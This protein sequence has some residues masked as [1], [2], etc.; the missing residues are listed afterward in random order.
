M[1]SHAA[2]SI[3]TRRS[4]ISRIKNSENQESWREFYNTYWKLVYGV[5]RRAG[6]TDAEAQDAVQETFCH[7]VKSIPA[8]RYDPAVGSFKSWLLHTTRWHIADQLRARAK[9]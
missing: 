1:N 8:F 9:V 4:L 7:V 2:V 5:A 3:Q 6:L